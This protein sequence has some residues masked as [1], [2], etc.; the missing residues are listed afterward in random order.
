M[1]KRV[2]TP[3]SKNIDIVQILC[4]NFQVH[5]YRFWLQY[6]KKLI[7]DIFYYDLRLALA[8]FFEYWIIFVV[9]AI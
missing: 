7:L 2:N 6:G 1:V 5:M 9:K 4:S 8:F 3:R